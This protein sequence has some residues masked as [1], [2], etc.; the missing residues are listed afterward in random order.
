MAVKQSSEIQELITQVALLTER[1]TSLTNAVEKS[2]NDHEGRIRD[3]ESSRS[4]MSKDISNI[5][6]RMTV[7]NLL[8]GALTAVAA[9]L[10]YWLGKR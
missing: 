8:Q 2:V 6:E 1:V 10:A 3:L 4:D 7:F 5:R 9:S